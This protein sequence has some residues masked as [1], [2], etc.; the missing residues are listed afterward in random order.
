MKQ[1]NLITHVIIPVIIT[2]IIATAAAAVYYGLY[3]YACKLV[4]IAAPCVLLNHLQIKLNN[5]Q[6]NK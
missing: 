6:T 1:F 4:I 5:K 3:S 2:G